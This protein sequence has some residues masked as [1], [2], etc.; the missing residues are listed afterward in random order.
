MGMNNETTNINEEKISR[1]RF[2]ELKVHLTLRDGSYRNGFVKNIY[3]DYFL[4]YDDVNGNEP[5]FFLELRNV[6]PYTKKEKEDGK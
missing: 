3:D 2:S 1:A 6:E 5:I 4:F